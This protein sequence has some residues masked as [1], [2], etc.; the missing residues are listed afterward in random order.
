[1][2]IHIYDCRATDL[3][4]LVASDAIAVRNRLVAECGE[5]PLDMRAICCWIAWSEASRRDAEWRM[6]AHEALTLVEQ[7]VL[8]DRAVVASE[9][10][11]A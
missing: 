7:A 2:S 6:I 1:M 4:N 11:S 8:L 10:H 3:V 9:E 5:E